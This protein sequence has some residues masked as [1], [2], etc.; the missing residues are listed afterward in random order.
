MKQKKKQQNR[1]W[2]L[3]ILVITGLVVALA[4]LVSIQEKQITASGTVGVPPGTTAPEFTLQSTK[5]EIS[6]ADYKGQNVVLF[7][8]EGNG[9]KACVDQLIELDEKAAEYAENNTV[10][11]AATTDPVAYS[12]QIAQK[13]DIQVPII[14]DKNQ[15]IGKQ[16][17]ITDVPGGMDM[18][19]V[20]THS[21]FVIDQQGSVSWF[22]ISTQ[23]MY[24]PI[25]SIEEELQKLWQ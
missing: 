6:L 5:G 15:Q 12:E 19:P 23:D 3:G 25:Q 18:G 4:V 9:C 14:Y 10:V 17:G 20:D 1:N 21:V 24:V 7:F 2:I 11:L 16:Y 8:Y 22:E 13:H